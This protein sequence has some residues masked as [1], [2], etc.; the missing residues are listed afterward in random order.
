VPTSTPAPRDIVRIRRERWRVVERLPYPACTALE[1]QGIGRDNR[2]I[3]TRFLLPFEPC[4]TVPRQALPRHVTA[5]RCRRLLR[6]EIAQA[7][8]RPDSL[9]TAV[10]ATFA[11]LP[12][13]LEPALA[14][15]GGDTVRALVADGVG[16]G[17]TVQAG[18]LVAE[19]LARQPDAHVLIVTPAPLRAQWQDE[20]STRFGIRVHA[21]DAD[22]LQRW[23][24]GAAQSIA[25]WASWSPVIV[26][27]D[28]LKRPEVLRSLEPLV[29]DLVV[30]DE[31]HHLASASDRHR[32]ASA[33]ARQALGVLLLS[34]TPHH[35]DDGRWRRLCEIGDINGRFPLRVFRRT[36][37]G[38]G[39]PLERRSVW[40][41]TR[42][43]RAERH[44]HQALLAYARRVWREQ[45]SP[46]ARLAVL[47]LLK[48]AGAGS[49]AVTRSLIRR[50]ELLALDPAAH[51]HSQLEL[52]LEDGEDEDDSPDGLL[53]SPGLAGRAD[54]IGAL[55]ALI[56]LASS[57]APRDTGSR[58]GKLAALV[59]LVHRTREPLIVFTQ[60]RDSLEEVVEALAPATVAAV[61]GG[62]PVVERARALQQFTS[63]TVRVL[64][65]TD[66]ASEGLNLHARCRLVV[67][68]DL[69]WT[70][71]KLEQRI[72]RVD[73]IGQTRR[74]HAVLLVASNSYEELV[75]VRLRSRASA[76]SAA[77]EAHGPDSELDVAAAVI[78]AEPRQPGPS[79]DAPERQTSALAG[80]AE[81]EAARVRHTRSLP[82]PPADADELR[83]F[84]STLN[85]AHGDT[86]AGW[87]ITL[88]DP[89]GTS[90]FSTL[91]GSTWHHAPPASV[92]PHLSAAMTE[93]LRRSAPVARLLPPWRRRAAST[94]RRLR[95]IGTVLAASQ[96]RLA[97]Q[98]VQRSLFGNSAERGVTPQ[99]QHLA[100]AQARIRVLARRMRG[101]SRVQ[102]K[103]VALAFVLRRR[104][105]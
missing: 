65:A 26:S 61:H 53:G 42:E 54:E 12:F 2:G 77:L 78:G 39:R 72:G 31:A 9:R 11:P 30:F 28:F 50:R 82:G 19:L 6:R 71:V 83:P 51:R 29:W 81:S 21:A 87:R 37:A 70:P 94:L 67:C 69:P 74:V 96:A 59:R 76:A 99:L 47:V 14:F 88:S 7:L 45:A 4:Q 92:L 25:P 64:A 68:L 35:G 32:A 75:A 24:I 34:A 55:D 104:R 101:V 93:H 40:L 5:E 18:L 73:R 80:L 13:Q 66:A 15:L 85:G 49:T 1:V 79:S 8:P 105:S 86:V 48:R 33:V 98:L 103:D 38:V 46:G 62:L 52:P 90:A 17:K 20:L 97:A 56:Q 89:D 63:G 27:I 60:Y 84:L 91:V 43:T 100:A 23:S 36:H 102:L 44:L 95:A 58:G 16:L 22:S 10:H 57:R 3:R 41:R